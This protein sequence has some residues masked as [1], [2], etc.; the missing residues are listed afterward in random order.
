MQ[1]KKKWSITLN[2]NP[3][4]IKFRINNGWDINLGDDGPD[5]MLEFNGAN[6]AVSTAGNYT[7]GI[8]LLNGGNWRYTV[9]RN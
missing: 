9:S 5:G 4:A 3:G 1:Q 7:V 2:L 6:I 8:S